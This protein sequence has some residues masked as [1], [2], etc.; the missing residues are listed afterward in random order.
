MIP[1]AINGYGRIGRNVHRQLIGHPEVEVIAING[2]THDPKMR[3]HLLKYDSLHGKCEA[4]IKVEGNDM[5]V[6]GHKVRLLA[7]SDIENLPW[8]DLNIDIVIEAT[9]KAKTYDV[10]AK[11]IEA[12]AK[13]VVVSAPMKDDTPT[14]VV[15]INEDQLK[16]EDNVIS[17]ASCTTN[18]IAP[19]LKVMDE[20]FGIENVIVSSIHSTTSSQNILDN[21]SSDYRR[22]R[23]ALLSIIPTTTGSVKATAL[24]LPQLKGKIDGLAFRIPLPT[25]S[26]ED[27]KLV[28]QK[29]TTA[30]EINQTIKKAAQ[31]ERLK[32]VLGICE[33]PLVSVDFKTDS[34][35]A[36][37]DAISTKVIQGKYVQMLAWYDNE[38]GYAMRLTEMV[39]LL[40]RHL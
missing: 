8:K 34:H 3:A 36:I 38:W 32:G 21:Y 6:N 35:S 28:L 27:M 19:V 20:N 40:G 1:I 13:K 5:V 26:C 14:F 39:M 9:G 30:E 16:K 31:T 18:C 23:S 37:V 10:A 11:H 7:E 4:E 24:V 15:G 33:E 29:E 25:T 22:A 2:R 17:N 12:G